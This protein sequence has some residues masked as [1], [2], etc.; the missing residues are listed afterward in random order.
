MDAFLDQLHAYTEA[1]SE[2]QFENL[3]LDDLLADVLANLDAVIGKARASVE[4]EG[5]PV[6][7]GDR[8]QLIQLLQNL[9]GNGIKYCRADAPQVRIRACVESDEYCR[10]EICDNGIGIPEKSYKSVF[11]PFRRLHA[12]GEF[13]G[14]GLGLAT[15]KKIVERHGGTIWCRSKA[16]KGTSF[17]F[18]VP[19]V[20]GF[21]ESSGA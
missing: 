2:P 12:Q 19:L 15:C 10:V 3:Q 6:I 5:L 20:R 13:E 11:E 9:I 16:G 21:D 4:S 14:T 1:D 18:T 7:C 17:F 8:A